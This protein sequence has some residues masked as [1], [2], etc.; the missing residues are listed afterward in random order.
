IVMEY[1]RPNDQT[2]PAA[3]PYDTTITMKPREKL[4]VPPSS[5]DP[6]FDITQIPK[7]KTFILKNIYFPMGRHF[8]RESSYEDLNMVLEAMKENRFL[9]IQIEGLVCCISNV[10]DAYDLDSRQMDLSLNRARFIFEYL[11]ARGISESRLKYVGYGKS[12]PIIADEQTK[13]E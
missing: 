8:P 5:S 3:H 12:R 13:E 7:G 6:G 10:A 1:Q 11:K 9:A 2:R 4:I